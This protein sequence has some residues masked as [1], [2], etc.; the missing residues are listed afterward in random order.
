M[1]KGHAAHADF[2]LMVA[3]QAEIVAG[4]RACLICDTLCRYV[5]EWSHKHAR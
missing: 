2:R 1:R 3:N 4:L 5:I